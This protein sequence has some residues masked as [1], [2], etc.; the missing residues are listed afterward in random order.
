MVKEYISAHQCMFLLMG[1]CLG[2]AIMIT[3]SYSIWYAMQDA[4]LVPWL[5][6][7]PGLGLI[8]L[9]VS[10]NKMY[11]GQSL[12]Q[13]SDSILGLPGKFLSLI[14]L[15]YFLYLG[16]TVLRELVGFVNSLI[17]F[18]T[19]PTVIYLFTTIL[20]AYGIRM[21]I[22]VISKTFSL[23]IFFAFLLFT[24]IHL[25]SMYIGN[26]NYGN[27][28]PLLSVG[29]LPLLRGSLNFTVS[30][31][32][33]GIV[34]FSMLLHYVKNPRGLGIRL[35][36]GLFLAICSL[37][38]VIERALV[39]LG[40]ERATRLLYTTAG[41]INASLGGGLILPLMTINWF[42]FSLCEFILCYYAFVTGVAHLLKL[43]DYK[44]LILPTGAL[45]VTLGIYS[46]SNTI[47]AFT[48]YTSIWTVYGLSMEYG[49]PI[50]LWLSAMI[51]IAFRYQEL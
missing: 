41:G 15:S 23:L 3:P 4:L 34:L 8:G 22:E 46:Y 28:L 48:F 19:P 38:L 26:P 50:I 16:S 17:L 47:E 37:F 29:V 9:L 13:Y 6:L 14:L 40:P 30:P 39:T 10:L 24:I 32:G 11:P 7:L 12:V 51:K 36:T 1:A 18:E 45:M 43:S 44:P 31:V 33:E 2:I 27:L 21:G 5:C 35:S 49:I 20:C 25:L 42:V